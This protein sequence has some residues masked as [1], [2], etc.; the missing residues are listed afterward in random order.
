MAATVAE[1]FA[2][3]VALVFSLNYIPTNIKE[4]KIAMPPNIS[5]IS[6]IFFNL[7]FMIYYIQN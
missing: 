2:D 5:A 1:A 4:I 6:A 3:F 7:N